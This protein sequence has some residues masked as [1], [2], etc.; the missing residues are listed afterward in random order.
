MIPETTAA[1]M[2]AAIKVGQET[3]IGTFPPGRP[4]K[5]SSISRTSRRS[6]SSEKPEFRLH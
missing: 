6:R 3:C 2:A 1:T 5:S 4:L